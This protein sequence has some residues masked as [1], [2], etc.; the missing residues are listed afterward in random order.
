VLEEWRRSVQVA[1]QSCGSFMER[2]LRRKVRR[3]S[4]YGKV[5]KKTRWKNSELQRHL[6][7]V[8][9]GSC[10]HSG[11]MGSRYL[12]LYVSMYRATVVLRAD[13]R[14]LGDA[15]VRRD[16]QRIVE[17]VLWLFPREPLVISD[18]PAPVKMSVVLCFVWIHRNSYER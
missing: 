16:G 1:P 3:L 17:P 15:A 10:D 6:I 18:P 2:R 4:K 5:Q 13:L 14:Y 11:A 8:T 7:A 12:P 9:K